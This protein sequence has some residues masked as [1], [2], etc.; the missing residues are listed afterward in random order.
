M[1][2]NRLQEWVAIQRNPSSGSGAGREELVRLVL[3]LQKYGYQVRL[4]K[5]RDKLLQTLNNPENRSRL[6]CLVAAG[7]DGTVNDVLN[8]YPSVPISLFPMG[9]ENLLAKYLQITDSGERL[10]EIIHEGRTEKFDLCQVNG[11]KFLLM[12]SFGIDADVVHRTSQARKG[13]ISKLNYVQPF[14][15]SVRNYEYPEIRIYV[16]DAVEPVVGRFGII[17]NIPAYALQLPFATE[18]SPFDGRLDL[19]LFEK[20]SLWSTM[21]YLYYVTNRWHEDRD[22]VTCLSGSRF[23]LESDVPVPIQVDGD[24]AGFTPASIE[25]SVSDVSLLVPKFFLSDQPERIPQ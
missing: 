19:R 1:P 6:K 10:A 9:T 3:R 20:G 15:D 2:V 7:G 11:R 8:R 25:L 22:D 16:D 5:D 24:P 23:R 21:E 4:F 12:A 18:A 17:S 14:W 13:N